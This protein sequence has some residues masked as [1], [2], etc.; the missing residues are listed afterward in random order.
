[1]YPDEKKKYPLQ[2]FQKN[3][4]TTLFQGCAFFPKITA[5]T[6]L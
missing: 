2:Q 5:Y 1:M 3:E 6:N 4:G